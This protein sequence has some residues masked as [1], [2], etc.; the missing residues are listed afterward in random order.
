MKYCIVN[1][2]DF[3]ASKGINRGIIE[4]HVNGILTSTSLMVNMP[5]STDAVIQSR[6]LPDLSIGLHLTLTYENGQPLID[7]DSPE[8]CSAELYQQLQRF[9]DQLNLLPTHLDSHHNVHRD[10]RVL[11]HFLKM[12]Q[13]YGLPMREHSP[14][15]YFSN[16]YGQW[17]GE[18]HVEHIGVQSLIEMLETKIGHGITELSCHPG[19]YDPKF[20]SSY[21][22]EREIELQT[23]CDQIV[24][25]K[26][27]EFG[28][29][30]LN[31]RDLNNIQLSESN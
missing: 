1:G 28:I 25:K 19:Y 12:A 26:I 11:P 23:L 4:A 10:P 27:V 21:H 5:Q 31:F 15:L 24:Q 6:D 3:G 29:R 13:R 22:R 2:D 16:F 18:S 9:Q 17:D 30:L 8:E 20:N 14:A 7:F